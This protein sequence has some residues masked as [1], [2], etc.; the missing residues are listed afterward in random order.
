MA[1]FVA[2]LA[3]PG[4]ASLDIAKLSVLVASAI[5]AIVG[6]IMLRAWIPRPKGGYHMMV[7]EVRVTVDP[8][9]L[10]EW[11]AWIVPHMRQVDRHG[12]LQLSVYSSE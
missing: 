7:Y 11:M 2:N 9:I 12:L 1:L 6:S 4:S 8:V 10:E 5:S 3:F